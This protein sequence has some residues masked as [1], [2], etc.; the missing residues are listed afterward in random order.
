MRS[1]RSSLLRPTIVGIA[2]AFAMMTAWA[3][4]LPEP[5]RTPAIFSVSM[6][7]MTDGSISRPQR[8]TFSSPISGSLTPRM[9]LATRL[10][11]SRR[12][13]ARA[14]KYSSSICSN[15]TACSSAALRTAFGALPSSSILAMML[16]AIIGSCTIMRCAS[17][18]AACSFMSLLLSFSM[19]S[20][21]ISATAVSASCAFFFSVSLSSGS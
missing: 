3:V 7:A 8:M 14:A 20:R 2:R 19:L 15:M 11:T 13:T 12:S 6:P 18:M 9:Y 10:P 5:S 16:S 4:V 17:M 1:M 21:R